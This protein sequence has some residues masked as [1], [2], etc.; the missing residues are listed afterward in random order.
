HVPLVVGNR[1]VQFDQSRVG[2]KNCIASERLRQ[3]RLLAE[4]NGAC[5]CKNYGRKNYGRK[6]DGQSSHSIPYG[7]YREQESC[8]RRYIFRST[9]IS[10]WPNGGGTRDSSRDIA[11]TT[12]RSNTA[13]C[14]ADCEWRRKIHALAHQPKNPMAFM[15]RSLRMARPADVAS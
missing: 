10:D 7:R 4:N 5:H 3:I 11:G 1:G 15:K 6:C 14:A 8:Q 2:P 12:Q 9:A 13:I